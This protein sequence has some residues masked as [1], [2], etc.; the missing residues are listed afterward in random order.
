[1]TLRNAYPGA[2]F[3]SMVLGACASGTAGYERLLRWDPPSGQECAAVSA[4]DHL[5]P[6]SELVDSVAV[7]DVPGRVI[8]ALAFDSVGDPGAPRVVES[9]LSADE[10][11]AVARAVESAVR[12]QPPSPRF[13]VLLLLEPGSVRVGRSEG[14]PP[15]LTN[16]VEIQRE[17][18]GRVGEYRQGSARP[19]LP[20][21]PV[22]VDVRVDTTGI[23]VDRRLHQISGNPDI[24]RIVLEVAG[25]MTFHP[26]RLNG[27]AVEVWSRVPVTLIPP[28]P[29][30]GSRPR[31]RG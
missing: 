28:P 8:F 27:R 25:G 7:V 12:H 21:R 20:R 26:A 17:V 18:S 3:L 29:A 9:D 6:V 13:T 22:V 30:T 19:P 23:V 11:E 31:N 1:M 4:P 14:C 5:P 10:A 16:R 2:L 24:D 15:V